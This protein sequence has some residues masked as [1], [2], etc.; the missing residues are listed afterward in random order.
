MFKQYSFGATN[1]A[2]SECL[3]VA[4]YIYGSKCVGANLS[5]DWYL[6]EYNILCL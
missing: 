1:S 4:F 3:I 6:G 2:I 5:W